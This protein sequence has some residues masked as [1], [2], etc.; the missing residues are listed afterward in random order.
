LQEGETKF[1]I[2]GGQ[3]LGFCRQLWNTAIRRIDNHRRARAGVLPWH[4][5]LVVGPADVDLGPTLRTL[6]FAGQPRPLYIQFDALRS[7]KKFLVRVLGGALQRRVGFLRP[8]TLEVG[9]TPRRSVLRLP[10]WQKPLEL[11]RAPARCMLKSRLRL[12]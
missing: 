1:P 12:F 4:E 10:L 7:G 2:C 3:L 5:H 9:L 8:N 11:E 6:V